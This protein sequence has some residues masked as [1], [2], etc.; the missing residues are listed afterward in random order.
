MPKSGTGYETFS[1]TLGSDAKGENIPKVILD[2]P[3]VPM[4]TD[5]F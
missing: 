2:N 3:K 5:F 1:K 4:T